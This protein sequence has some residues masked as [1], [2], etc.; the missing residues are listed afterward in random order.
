MAE[1]GLVTSAVGTVC[2]LGR[3]AHSMAARCGNVAIKKMITFVLK[4][5]FILEKTQ[6][7]NVYL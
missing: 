5:D 3:C 6:N 7:R 1:V 4:K 2:K